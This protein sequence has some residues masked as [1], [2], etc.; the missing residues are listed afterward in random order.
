MNHKLPHKEIAAAIMNPTQHRVVNELRKWLPS[1]G[2]VLFTLLVLGVLYWSQSVGAISFQAPTAATVSTD[3]IA[4]QGQL[5]DSN[6]N[7]VTGTY[8]MRFKFYSA[9]NGGS[10]LWSE[11]WTGTN[12]VQVTDGLFNVMLG[13]LTSIPQSVIANNANLFLGITI[14][15]DQEMTPRVQLGS[16]PFATKALTV[17]DASIGTSKLINGA[18]TSSKIAPLNKTVRN[19]GGNTWPTSGD[20]TDVPG[21]TITFTADEI[22]T[23]ST[24]MIFYT[25]QFKNDSGQIVWA[26]VLVD[27]QEVF[28][29]QGAG[30]Q[31]FMISIPATYDVSPGAHTVKAQY[32]PVLGGTATASNYSLSAMVVG[33]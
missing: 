32:K 17:P 26:R 29:G 4:Y 31:W 10:P 1:R 15:S 28:M 24:I 6:G 22:L 13:S 3:T 2:T 5:A 12:S 25:Q 33:R 16:V 14:G 27:G 11:D 21:A 18:V 19:R 30:S 20:W 7:P 9:A 23:N 8:D